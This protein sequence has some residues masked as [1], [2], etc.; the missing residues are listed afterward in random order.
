[1]KSSI[2]KSTAKKSS[3]RFQKLF[4]S[5]FALGIFVTVNAQVHEHNPAVVVHKEIRNSQAFENVEIR[6]DIT[7][8]LTNEQRSDIQLQG[9]LMDIDMVTTVEKDNKLE[10]TAKK[11]ASEVIVFVPVNKMHSLKINGDAKVFSSGDIVVDD[12]VIT[13]KGDSMVK[14]YH[15]GKLTVIPAEGYEK[16][17]VAAIY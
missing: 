11:N 6:G 9:N 8:V 7:L 2:R 4:M 16:A 14:V 13:L 1:M 10:I 5:V 17:D 15:H 3:I 12:L